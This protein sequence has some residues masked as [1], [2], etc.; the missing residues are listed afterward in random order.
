MR[1]ADEKNGLVH[2]SCSRWLVG[3][4]LTRMIDIHGLSQVNAWQM[5]Y[6]PVALGEIQRP[7]HPPNTSNSPA[8]SINE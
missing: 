5:G 4:Y 3:D 2:P 8:L 1:T 7:A 6:E